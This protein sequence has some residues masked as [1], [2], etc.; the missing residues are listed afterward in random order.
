MVHS[1]YYERWFDGF[2]VWLLGFGGSSGIRHYGCRAEF[3][4]L[5]EVG[6]SGIFEKECPWT[7][8]V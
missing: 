7:Q 3:S 8:M 5:V 6:I 4:E 2:G 1:E